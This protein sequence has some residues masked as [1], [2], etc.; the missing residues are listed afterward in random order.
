MTGGLAVVVITYALRI[1]LIGQV[2]VKCKLSRWPLKKPI[3]FSAQ[4]GNAFYPITKCYSLFSERPD[5][6]Y[7]TLFRVWVNGHSC[8]FWFRRILISFLSERL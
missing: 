3:P 6:F 8:D 5:L 1:K 7:I 2:L 4:L